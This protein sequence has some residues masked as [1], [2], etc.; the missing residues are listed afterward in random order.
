MI[1]L[2]VP[3]PSDK[4]IAKQFRI[5][6]ARSLSTLRMP[7]MLTGKSCAVPPFSEVAAQTF[8]GARMF[9]ANTISLIGGNDE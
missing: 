5:G 7:W 3:F 9:A 4:D 8:V 2:A 1:F 6:T